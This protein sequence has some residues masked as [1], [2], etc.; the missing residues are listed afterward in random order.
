M[1]AA[2]NRSLPREASRGSKTS[3]R[4]DV[5]QGLRDAPKHL[6]CKYLYDHAGSE[7]FERITELDEYYPTR[8]EQLI[9]EEHVA[10]MAD[11]LGEE[12]LLVEYGSGSS[13]KTRRLLD[14][15]AKPAGYIP[16][17][18]SGTHLRESADLLADDYPKIEVL[19]LCA[20]FTRMLTLPAPKRKPRR[21][22]VYFPG[23]TIG[24]FK[25]E[26][27]VALLKRTALL[28]GPGGGLLLGADLRKDPSIIE[29]AYNDSLGIT[30]AFNRNLLVR[31]N[32]ELG[33]DF[34]VNQFVHRSFFNES[35]GRIEMH[36]V[37]Q[38]NQRVHLGDETIHFAAGESIHTE[39][40][41][42]YSLQK[43]QE[44]AKAGGFETQR[45]WTDASSYFSVIYLSVA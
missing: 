31:I 21:T 14:H 38:V 44:L 34:K 4:E 6:P 5:L 24:N 17:D 29:R 15:L 40:S 16:I 25:P 43:L 33:A 18:V 11:L 27:V 35:H 45:V 12:C 13:T 36:L 26:E 10:E 32:R 7:L 19:P 37:S 30:A 22:V 39:N 8:T 3:F 1:I 41:Y 23:S 2:L 9:M 42:K 28:C 20:D